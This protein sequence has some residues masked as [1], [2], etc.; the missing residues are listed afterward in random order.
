MTATYL[1]QCENN[2]KRRRREVV[3]DDDVDDYEP[4]YD[5][6][7]DFDPPVSFLLHI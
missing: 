7:T 5:F 1:E 4:S 6:D 3:Y 2:G